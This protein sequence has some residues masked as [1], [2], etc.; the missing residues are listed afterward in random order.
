MSRRGTAAAVLLLHAALLGL[1]AKA[2]ATAGAAEEKQASEAGWVR[3]SLPEYD[4]LWKSARRPPEKTPLEAAFT[5]TT[6][7]LEAEAGS[8]RLHATLEVASLSDKPQMLPLP[9]LG[10][11]YASE[12][13]G[14]GAALVS[15]ESGELQLR[16]TR[17]SRFVVHVHSVPG[18]EQKTGAVQISWRVPD[19]PSN[20]FTATLPA[21]HENVTLAGGSFSV[22]AGRSGPVRVAGTLRRGEAARFV[23]AVAEARAPEENL[24]ASASE[25]R[26]Y[27]LGEKSLGV[28]SRL[29][30]E[31]LRGTL[32][33][34]AVEASPELTV[35]SA[36]AA[37]N[38]VTSFERD[39]ERPGRL[40]LTLER[41]VMGGTVEVFFLLEKPARAEAGAL[42]LPE[43]GLPDFLRGENA[44]AVTSPRPVVLDEAKGRRD[45]YER[46]DE[47]DLP[48]ELREIAD[49]TVL[50]ALRRIGVAPPAL[51]LH[52][53]SFP[54]ASGLEGVIDRAK[55]L[56]VAARDGSRVDRWQ[57]ELQTRES[58]VRIPLPAHATLWSLQVDGKPARPQTEQGQLL[59]AL[60]RGEKAARTRRLEIVLAI[61]GA[62]ALPRRGPARVDMPKLPFPVT[63]TEWD[64]LLPETA[65][66]R[67]AGGTVSP[68][69][70][71]EESAMPAARTAAAS[72]L[73]STNNVY[74]LDGAAMG[75][76][77]GSGRLTGRVLD[78]QGGALPGVNVAL[79]GKDNAYQRNTTT[80]AEGHFV[81]SDAPEGDFKMIGNLQGLAAVER[82]IALPE[83]G[84]V[85]A[86]LKMPLASAV[87]VTVAAEAPVIDRTNAAASYSYRPDA[88]KES[89]KAPRTKAE[90][91][92]SPQRQTLSDEERASLQRTMEAGVAAIAVELPVEGKR[93]HFEGSL[94]VDEAA[95]IEFQVRPA[96][97][98]WLG[99]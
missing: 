85:G 54:N 31:V 61:P 1:P 47:T 8:P 99:F 67:Y 66:Y 80:D 95:S 77:R 58:L 59:V 19:S 72:G 88:L 76:T 49:A 43:I 83:G 32:K 64:L 24:L 84:N 79:V 87:E 14:D 91:A 6:F 73:T 96:R 70:A 4:R 22:Q 52:V 57:L 12:V 41:G 39:P 81:F 97:R 51:A 74:N 13:S 50:L 90:P 2:L 7:V 5:S 63:H 30:I 40:V 21:G 18:R 45:G 27:R 55:V 48:A 38:T 9:D 34:F 78:E 68:A 56:T 98:G 37:G 46:I 15:G 35:T 23:Y 10:V 86:D 92:P 93:L 71:H 75:K 62:L 20:R 11:L 17:R 60:G 65:Q 3:L 42:M 89:R 29:R 25:S 94:L 82:S 69:P 36:W 28:A 26:L 44:V 53:S 33:T 16:L